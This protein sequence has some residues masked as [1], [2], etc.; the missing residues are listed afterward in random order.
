MI[1]SIANYFIVLL[2]RTVGYGTFI[3]IEKAK[4]QHALSLKAFDCFCAPQAQLKSQV[5][6]LRTLATFVIKYFFL[7]KNNR[8]IFINQ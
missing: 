8:T 2:Y 5:I 7:F 3:I 1:Y 6:T 4:S